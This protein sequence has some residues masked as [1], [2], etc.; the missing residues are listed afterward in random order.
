MKNLECSS[1][2]DK[3]FSA[4]YA[5]VYV[6]KKLDSIE[7]HYQKSKVFLNLKTNET[8]QCEDFKRTKAIQYKTK[9]YKL[10]GFN[11]N[12]IFLEKEFLSDWYKA[13]WYK[14][15][16]TN[17]HLLVIINEYDTFTDCFKRKNTINSQSDVMKYI[18]DFGLDRLYQDIKPFFELL[19]NKNKCLKQNEEHGKE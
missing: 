2:G 14:Y 17:K 3:R 7:N 11:I 9:D 19:K 18:K 15:L 1:K 6:N 5:K 4:L 13:L 16:I 10:I 12:G 8:F